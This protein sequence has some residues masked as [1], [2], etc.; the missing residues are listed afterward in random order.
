[1]C[2][3]YLQ[4]KQ[5]DTFSQHGLFKREGVVPV[6]VVT[7]EENVSFYFRFHFFWRRHYF[8]YAL[9]DTNLKEDF[10]KKFFCENS[11]FC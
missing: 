11:C 9:P 3:K 8:M 6:M 1:M 10:S 4:Y 2:G 7:E 5:L